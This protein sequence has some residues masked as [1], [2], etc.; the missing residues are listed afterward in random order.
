V[1]KATGLFNNEADNFVEEKEKDVA[2]VAAFNYNDFSK[3]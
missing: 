3:S 1:N 2:P